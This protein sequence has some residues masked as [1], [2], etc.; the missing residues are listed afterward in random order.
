MCHITKLNDEER[1]RLMRMDQA[2]RVMLEN[3]LEDGVASTRRS[4]VPVFER[5]YAKWQEINGIVAAARTPERLTPRR[6]PSQVVAER[7]ETA[8]R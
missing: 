6:T 3:A 2:H 8:A 7:L 5:F 4:V 1:A